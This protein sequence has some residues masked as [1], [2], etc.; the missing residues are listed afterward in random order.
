M[1]DASQPKAFAEP[2]KAIVN[3]ADS[4][5]RY[6]RKRRKKKKT[7][8]IKLRARAEVVPRLFQS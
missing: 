2:F 5:I 6:N 1:L 8:C 4:C 7:L 3:S